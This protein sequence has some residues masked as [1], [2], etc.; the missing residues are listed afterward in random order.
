MYKSQS[1]RSEL[2]IPLSCIR[3][4]PAPTSYAV[5]KAGSNDRAYCSLQKS[6]QLEEGVQVIAKD[7]LYY[8][9][10]RACI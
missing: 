2:R 8:L 9:D 10:F 5:G 1:V 3:I 6:C 4:Y 7:L